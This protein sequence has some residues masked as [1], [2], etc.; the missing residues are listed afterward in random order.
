L[1]IAHPPASHGTPTI[2]EILTPVDTP[3]DD[4]ETIMWAAKPSFMF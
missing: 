2:E 1:S 3:E 4:P